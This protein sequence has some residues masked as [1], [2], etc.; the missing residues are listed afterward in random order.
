MDLSYLDIRKKQ[1]NIRQTDL[2]I[3]VFFLIGISVILLWSAIY[4]FV[5]SRP[6][7]FGFVPLS[8]N[9]KNFI[10]LLILVFAL[11]TYLKLPKRSHS[12]DIMA[13]KRNTIRQYQDICKIFKHSAAEVAPGYEKEIHLM[14]LQRVQILSKEIL[15]E[16]SRFSD[17][18]NDFF[19]K[20]RELFNNF[21]NDFDY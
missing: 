1:F 19:L 17:L 2:L 4:S 7:I 5:V 18:D 15:A 6:D 11:I 8:G 20:N 21:K 13:K 10:I 14:C 9:I 12:N 16:D 3:L